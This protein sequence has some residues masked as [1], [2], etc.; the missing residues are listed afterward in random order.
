MIRAVSTHSDV[1]AGCFECAGSEALW[2]TRNA[3]ALAARHHDATGH[4]TWAEQHLSI[5]YGEDAGAGRQA[6][7][8]PEGQVDQASRQIPSNRFA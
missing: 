5:H 6:D 2:T 4:Q 1:S 7:L 8:F 3:V